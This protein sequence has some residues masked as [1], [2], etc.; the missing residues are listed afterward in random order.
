ML[1]SWPCCADIMG[2]IG[3]LAF[4]PTTFALPAIIWLILKEPKRQ[5][6]RS[7]LPCTV[8]MPSCP[9]HSV[10]RVCLQ[11]RPAPSG[12]GPALD[13]A[14]AVPAWHPAGTPDLAV[15]E[16]RT[17]LPEKHTL[18]AVGLISDTI[19]VLEASACDVAQEMFKRHEVGKALH[20]RSRACGTQQCQSRDS[21]RFV[22]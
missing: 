15:H 17:S 7:F 16:L 2:F 6:F 1:P 21:G 18:C 9:S 3:A 14:P 12:S 19:R 5:A 11:T 10:S 22:R 8:C 4:G 13:S 20:L